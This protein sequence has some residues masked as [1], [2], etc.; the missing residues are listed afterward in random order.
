M[1]K[2][3]FERYNE[4]MN[5][6]TSDADIRMAIAQNEDDIRKK[7]K[8][9]TIAS[10]GGGWG[11]LALLLAT[12]FL[13]GWTLGVLWVVATIAGA[14]IISSAVAGI[15][16]HL[17]Y[18]R[19]FR[20]LKTQKELAKM[21]DG[22]KNYS[23]VRRARLEKQ[24]NKD[25]AF[26]RKKR[27]ISDRELNVRS[28]IS[29]PIVTEEGSLE[30]LAAEKAAEADKYNKTM[31]NMSADVIERCRSDEIE[32]L[33][34]SRAENLED[35]KRFEGSFVISS[36][37]YDKELNPK[38]DDGGEIKKVEVKI[39]A[40]SDKDYAKNLYA[41][42]QNIKDKY[43]E[44]SLALPF[45]FKICDSA[46]NTVEYALKD[47]SGSY[48]AE[49]E[50]TD[51]NIYMFDDLMAQALEMKENLAETHEKKGATASAEA[52]SEATPVDEASA[53][54]GG[55]TPRPAEHERGA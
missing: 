33:F 22:D 48:P 27:M 40:Q 17:K 25:L 41:I 5:S 45:T 50:I 36:V 49:F 54:A 14:G 1:L 39:E 30:A 47:R 51:E 38:R 55:G 26:C 20:A 8:Y 43:K 16:G 11:S 6:L 2:K 29:R 44:H 34:G 35:G 18:R 7:S 24:L 12:G 31:A 13:S 21:M 19:Y 10:L 42:S 52:S 15:V 9:P 23:D 3:E 46:G 28:T 53:G 32:G 4:K 37:E